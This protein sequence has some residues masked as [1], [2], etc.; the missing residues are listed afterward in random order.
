MRPI[1]ELLLELPFAHS[2]LLYAQGFEVGR[3]QVATLTR[4]LGI[5][6]MNRKPRKHPRHPV[7]PQLL[8][9]L[10]IGR[11]KPISAMDITYVPMARGFVFLTAALGGHRRG[12]LAHRMSITMEAHLCVEVLAAAAIAR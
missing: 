12:V 3:R 5:E 6:A 10:A 8:C 1:D 11:A 7:F 9:R 2:D 4:K